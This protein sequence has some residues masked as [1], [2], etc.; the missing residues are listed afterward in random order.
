MSLKSCK[1]DYICHDCQENFKLI[2]GNGFCNYCGRL[3]TFKINICNDC[4]KWN[5]KGWSWFKSRS[6]YVYNDFMSEY[7]KKYKFNGDYYLRKIFSDEFFHSLCKKQLI[8]PIPVSHET[9]KT[10]KFNQVHGLIEH[11][12]FED[13]LSVNSKKE[14]QS[15]HNKSERMTMKQVFGIDSKFKKLIVGKHITIVDDVYTTGTTIRL[16][17]MVLKENGAKSVSGFT[18][19]R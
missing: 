14:M 6:M 12:K 15:H 16:A 13:I 9:M 7:M 5:Q 11:L 18:L 17:A 1:V 4:V 3:G 10:R 2:S 8:V 19:A